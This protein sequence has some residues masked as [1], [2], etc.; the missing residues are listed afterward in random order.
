MNLEIVLLILAS[1]NILAIALSI[2]KK[3]ALIS[4]LLSALE[5]LIV[6]GLIYIK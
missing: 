4:F 2:V 1:F 3:K 6:G 5:I